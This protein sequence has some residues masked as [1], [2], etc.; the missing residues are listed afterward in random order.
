M[1]PVAPARVDMLLG[2]GQP[3]RPMRTYQPSQRQLIRNMRAGQTALRT[4][5]SD[6]SLP[7]TARVKV[8]RVAHQMLDHLDHEPV[9]APRPGQRVSRSRLILYG[10]AAKP[11]PR[12]EAL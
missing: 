3:P 2:D 1:K 4:V 9:Q 11:P 5:G 7:G 6:T 10:R 12:E 8:L